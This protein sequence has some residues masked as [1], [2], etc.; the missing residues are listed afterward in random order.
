LLFADRDIDLM[1]LFVEGGEAH[2]E[3]M[4]LAGLRQRHARMI[5]QRKRL[6]GAIG[7]TIN[8]RD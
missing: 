7:R 8:Y 1:E 4:T 6:A 3:P 5:R 2:V